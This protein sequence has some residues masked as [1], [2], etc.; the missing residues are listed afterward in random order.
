MCWLLPFAWVHNTFGAV[1]A[2]PERGG[3]PAAPA[4]VLRQLSPSRGASCGAGAA[5]KGSASVPG[6]AA[7]VGAWVVGA[8]GTASAAQF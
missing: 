8:G 3:A 7:P 1:G 5:G 2:G 6:G 4:L